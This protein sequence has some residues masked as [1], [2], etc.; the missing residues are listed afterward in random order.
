M[1]ARHIMELMAGKS[2]SCKTG[3]F[4]LT[5]A[6]LPPYSQPA[7]EKAVAC[8]RWPVGAVASGRIGMLSSGGI[9]EGAL[10]A[11]AS[12]R[13]IYTNHARQ[14]RKTADRSMWRIV[15]FAHVAPNAPTR[16]AS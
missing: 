9:S 11:H 5:A 10:L 4:D 1:N 15:T 16:C 12:N 14:G 3:W 13:K 7:M 2:V 6:Q 8:A